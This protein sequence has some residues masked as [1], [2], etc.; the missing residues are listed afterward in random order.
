MLDIP[1][2]EMYYSHIKF[3]G[4][5]FDNLSEKRPDFYWLV[6]NFWIDLCVDLN[7]HWYALSGLIFYIF[8]QRWRLERIV[9][10]CWSTSWSSRPLCW[11]CD[12]ILWSCKV[13]STSLVHSIIMIFCTLFLLT[14]QFLFRTS[15]DCEQFFL[16]WESFQSILAIN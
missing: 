16:E 10:R 4:F 7:D 1:W 6:T 3:K 9:Y 12:F 8:F 5:F 14:K 11:N 15:G 13:C 2:Y